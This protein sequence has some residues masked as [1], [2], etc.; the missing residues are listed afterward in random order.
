MK[1][2]LN[3]IL[4]SR[5]ILNIILEGKIVY[6]EKLRQIERKFLGYFKISI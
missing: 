5:N 6:A 1:N 2:N 3:K 4:I